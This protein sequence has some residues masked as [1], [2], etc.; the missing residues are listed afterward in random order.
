MDL[1]R[2]AF[3]DISAGH[4]AGVVLS[5]PC[6]I[7]H[8]AYSDQIDIDAKRQEF[9]EEAKREGWLDEEAKLKILTAQGL[10]SGHKEDE[11]SRAKQLVVDLEESKRKNGN[12]YPSMVA[13]LVK[14]IADAEKEHQV[15]AAEKRQLL[16]QTCEFYADRSVNDHYIVA[17]LFGDPALTTPF[18][19]GSEFD[20]MRDDMIGQIVQDYNRSL[21]GCSEY[22]LRKLAMQPFFQRYFGLTGDDFVQFFGKPICQLTFYQVDLLRYGAH[23]RHIYSSNDVASFPKKVLEDPD[24]LTEYASAAGKTKENLEKQ[25]ANSEDAV[26]LGLSKEDAKAT[27]IQQQP[28][29]MNDIMKHGGNVTEWLSKR[30]K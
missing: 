6:Y 3:R 10:W 16:G 27:G 29:V 28:G 14:Q 7:K 24:L 30:R 17:N 2:R 1:L 20:Y 18:F 4:T 13:S 21:E 19:V 9:F 26:V 5:R 23:F 15:K 22:N 8:L 12:L 25:G 11:L